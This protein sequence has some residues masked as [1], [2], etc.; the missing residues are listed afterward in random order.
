MVAIKRSAVNAT[1]SEVKRLP[2]RSQAPE[3][4]GPVTMTH[5]LMMARI[6]ARW[7]MREKFATMHRI[8]YW[9]DATSSS[10]KDGLV[11]KVTRG[12]GD[13]AQDFPLQKGGLRNRM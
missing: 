6:T 13:D 1:A 9:H 4:L 11:R 7:R 10:W 5:I 8:A 3:A 12:S 2:T